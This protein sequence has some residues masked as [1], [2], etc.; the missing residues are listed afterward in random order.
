MSKTETTE[1]HSWLNQTTTESLDPAVRWPVKPYTVTEIE[2]LN[3]SYDS[4]FLLEIIVTQ[5]SG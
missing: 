5:F 1:K 2:T 3:E 4:I